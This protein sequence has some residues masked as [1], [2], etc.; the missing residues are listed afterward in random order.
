MQAELRDLRQQAIYNQ[1][2]AQSEK[3]AFECTRRKMLGDITN[4]QNSIA[5]E[6]IKYQHLMENLESAREAL[7][8]KES[9]L[10]K[11]AK[12]KED[13]VEKANRRNAE[14]EVTINELK[15]EIPVLSSSLGRNR[16]TQSEGEIITR[17]IRSKAD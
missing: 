11:C 10:L 14:F 12:E 15:G 9:E 7:R 1:A 5:A 4:L 16:I 17:F 8:S 6:R 13:T 3:E 2:Q